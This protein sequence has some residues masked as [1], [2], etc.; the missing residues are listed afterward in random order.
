MLVRLFCP[1]KMHGVGRSGSGSHIDPDISST[2]ARISPS[3][4]RIQILTAYYSWVR[5]SAVNH[6]SEIGRACPQWACVRF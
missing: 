6:G 4:S 3:E 1:K 2:P 5:N